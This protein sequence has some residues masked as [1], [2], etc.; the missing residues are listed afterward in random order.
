[1]PVDWRGAGVLVIE[2]KHFVLPQDESKA[3]C[4]SS[5]DGTTL[6]LGGTSGPRWACNGLVCATSLVLLST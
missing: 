3:A 6:A 1:M 4:P 2:Q 5:Y